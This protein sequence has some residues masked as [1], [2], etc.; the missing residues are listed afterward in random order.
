M[1][2]LID[3][4]LRDG[5]NVADIVFGHLDRAGTTLNFVDVG[6]RNG[7][8]MLP[9]SYAAR[10]RL[11]GFEPNRAE[12]DKLVSGRTDA[13]AAG[14]VEP[15]YREK[16][17]Y[18]QALWSK[19]GRRTLYLTQGP[20]A[21]TLM[22]PAS[23][24]MT[25]NMWREEDR[26]QNYYDRVQR[27]VDTVEVDCIT[28]DELWRENGETVDILKLDVEGGE[29]E[30]LKGA[31]GLLEAKKPLLIFTEF[32][33]LPFY[34][35]RVTLGH[36]QVFLDELGYRLIAINF[37]HFPYSWKPTN[38]RG[39][40]DRRLRY[41]GDAIF[42]LDPDRNTLDRD[43]M[44]RLGLACLSAGFDSLGLNLI[45]ETGAVQSNDIEAVED[46]ANRPPLLRWLRAAWTGVPHSA[47]R[48]LQALKLR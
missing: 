43:S 22:G 10:A 21:V 36:Q 38:I 11:T 17:Y 33:L 3:R 35:H 47:D 2:A 18:P 37:D 42:I 34:E 19:A 31:R 46:L 30:V 6:A 44:Y 5:R 27:V 25:G 4:A 8:F 9:R 16:K 26:D 14:L 24:R 48:L 29:L 15:S 45:R 28:L 20:G 13:R 32:L 23:E 1:S 7:S 39:R 41:A 12:Y 40:N